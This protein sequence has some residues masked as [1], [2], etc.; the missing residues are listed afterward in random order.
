MALTRN[1]EPS[2]LPLMHS[3]KH[4]A[5]AEETVEPLKDIFAALFFTC[6][7]VHVDAWYILSNLQLIMSILAVVS[8]FYCSS[9]NPSSICNS[10]HW[11]CMI[12]QSLHVV[13]TDLKHNQTEHQVTLMKLIVLSSMVKIS[14]YPLRASITV[15]NT[16]STRPLTTASLRT[17][18]ALTSMSVVT[19]MAEM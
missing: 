4:A 17:I 14:G 7:G 3:G 1:A 11:P 16:C 6:I 18:L 15:G 9:S 12:V 8:R 2:P 19:A 5:E 13:L 10:T